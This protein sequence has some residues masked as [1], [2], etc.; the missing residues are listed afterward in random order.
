MSNPFGTD[1]PFEAEE[2]SVSG[3]SSLSESVDVFV[4]C[5][6]IVVSVCL[7]G[8]CQGSLLIT[9]HA[10]IHRSLS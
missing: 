6:L 4:C 5:P 9:E 1:N 10:S 8:H 3:G 7:S 2:V